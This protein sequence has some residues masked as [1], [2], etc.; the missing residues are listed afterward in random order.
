MESTG[1]GFPH[2]VTIVNSTLNPARAG[3]T[4]AATTFNTG[5][6]LTINAGANIYMDFGGN[7]MTIPLIVNGNINLSGNLSGS[8]SIGGDIELKGNW[9]NNGAAVI[10]FFPNNRAVTFNGTIAQ[11]IGGSNT[12]VN[13][14]DYL[15]INNSSGVTLTSVNVEVDNQLSFSS[16]N[17]TIGN[18][19]L[20]LNGLNTPLTGANSTS[21]VVTNGTGVLSRNF[22]NTSTLYPIGPDGSTYAPVTLQQL[23]TADDIS[24]RVKTA[25]AFMFAVN[26]NNQMVN[27]EWIFNESVAGGNNISSNFQW[28]LSSEAAG[29]IRSNGVFQGDYSGAW[30]ARASI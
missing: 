22:N 29:F 21:Y 12:T 3:A 27:L 17:L 26:D 30:Q 16:G 15:T 9:N 13:P 28:P 5:G 19:N 1:K 23:G 6:N 18:F 8:G 10:N 2:H 24:V 7:N 25:P 20:K 11:T 14:F 4:F